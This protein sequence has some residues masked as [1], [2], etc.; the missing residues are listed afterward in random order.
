M[1]YLVYL[2]LF[3]LVSCVN[4]QNICKTS[5]RLSGEIIYAIPTRN[6]TRL[7]YLETP[8]GVV[9]IYRVPIEQPLVNIP[10]CKYRGE[11]YWVMP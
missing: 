11:Y 1:K 5:E 8:K 6:H 4:L 10:V 9:K 3:S 2:L 7:V